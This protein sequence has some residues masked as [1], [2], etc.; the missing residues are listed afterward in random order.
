M[1]EEEEEDGDGL[2]YT[3]NTLLGDSYTT[4]PSTGGHSLP[5]PAPTPS[6]TSGG[7]NPENNVVLCT[8]ELEA[9]IEAFLEEADED[10]E[11]N[12]LPLLEN[13]S[14]VPVPAPMVPSFVPLAI[15]AGQCCIPP[16]SL[17]MLPVVYKYALSYAIDRFT[18]SFHSTTYSNNLSPQRVEYFCGS[19]EY[20][21]TCST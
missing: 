3:T 5:S 21:T 4:P 17:I 1:E 18:S 15:S 12:D 13:T 7:S 8:K 20:T 6:S 11:M 19:V 9:R 16:K 14:L 10:L 2:E